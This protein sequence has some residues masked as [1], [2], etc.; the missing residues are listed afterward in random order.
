M[1]CIKFDDLLHLRIHNVSKSLHSCKL[2][3]SFGI[4]AHCLPMKH[5]VDLLNK[6][7]TLLNLMNFKTVMNSLTQKINSFSYSNFIM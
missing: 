7:I 4:F 2:W 3:S 6:S 5:K 1:K